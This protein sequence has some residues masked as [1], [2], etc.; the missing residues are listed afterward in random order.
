MRQEKN[1]ASV[2]ALLLLQ[3]S[4]GVVRRLLI[5]ELNL[6]CLENKCLL[7]YSQGGCEQ[8]CNAVAQTCSCGDKFVLQSDGRSCKRK[9]AS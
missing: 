3:Y 5:I 6:F 1:E 8:E 2:V 9:T 4:H 7:S